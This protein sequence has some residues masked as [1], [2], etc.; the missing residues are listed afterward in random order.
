ML[1]LI[2]IAPKERPLKTLTHNLQHRTWVSLSSV[3]CLQAWASDTSSALF[4]TPSVIS[5][6]HTLPTF[7]E[8]L[9]KEHTEFEVKDVGLV[10]TFQLCNLG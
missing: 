1:A 8:G 2:R 6:S 7:E 5:L 9:Q 4:S 10:C 3:S